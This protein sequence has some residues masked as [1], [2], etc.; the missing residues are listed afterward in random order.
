[1]KERN[2][3]DR[4]ALLGAIITLFGVTLAAGDALGAE[5]A[6]VTATAVA[7]HAA[8]RNTLAAAEK[9]N[10]EAAERAAESLALEAA[11]DLDIRLEDRTSSLSA[12][13]RKAR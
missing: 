1:M 8:G 13:R 5:D 11:I 2:I 6:D 3:E 4:L 12:G 9:A 10:N 7:I